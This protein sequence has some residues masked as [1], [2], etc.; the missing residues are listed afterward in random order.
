ME[1]CYLKRREIDRIAWDACVDRAWNGLPYAYSWWL[2][3]TAG[4]WDALVGDDY[5][6]V[7]PLPWNRR[8]WGMKQVFPPLFTQQLGLFSIKPFEPAA[9]L[10]FLEKIPS[11]F[12]RVCLSLNE[13]HPLEPHPEWKISERVNY[14]LDLSKGY[15]AVSAGYSRSLR[16]RVRQSGSLHTWIDRPLSP[17]ALAAFF[18]QYYGDKVGLKARSYRRLV[19][20]MHAALERGKAEVW[21]VADAQSGEL[22]AVGFFP[23]SHGRVINLFSAS[24]PRGRELHSM[25][26]LLDGVIR[27][28]AGSPSILDFEGSSIPSI[29]AF[30]A[31]FGGERR[32]FPMVCRID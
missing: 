14:L 24:S 22:G 5:E 18:V 13:C 15:E 11:N 20:L 23:I 16:Q 12:R 31:S 1:I 6:A 4:Q 21:G 2:D 8:Y 19:R 7:F 32:G 17:E 10:P 26:T 3:C 27:R 30:F 28:Y 25:H 9:G 29:A